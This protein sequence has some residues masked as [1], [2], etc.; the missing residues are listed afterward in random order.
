MNCIWFNFF[1]CNDSRVFLYFPGCPMGLFT[2]LTACNLAAASI[3]ALEQF[4][5]DSYFSST[6]T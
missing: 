3:I 5:T 1:N 2:N 6:T 4:M